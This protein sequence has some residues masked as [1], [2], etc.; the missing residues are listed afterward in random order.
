[1]DLKHKITKHNKYSATE[2]MQSKCQ[3]ERER[4]IWQ[5]VQAAHEQVQAEIAKVRDCRCQ[6]MSRMMSSP[7]CK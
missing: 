5:T 3:N 4:L 7:H 6:R 2:K 1:M